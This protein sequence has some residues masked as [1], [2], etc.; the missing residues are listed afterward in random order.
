MRSLTGIL[1]FLLGTAPAWAGAQREE[2]L[3]A[4]VRLA[5]HTAVDDT[6]AMNIAFANPAQAHA[7][8][9]EMSRRLRHKMPNRYMRRLF[10]KT[11]QYESI[12]AGLDPQ[13]V[14]GLIQVESGFNKYAVSSAGAMGYMQVM[15]FWIKQVG[16]PDDDL[17]AMRTNL[18]YGCTILRYYLDLEKGNLFR[19]LGLYNGSLGQAWYPERVL[20]AWRHDWPYHA[21][22]IVHDD[23]AVAQLGTP[24]RRTLNA[25]WPR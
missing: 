24:E 21:P 19:A 1:I 18:V 23:L 3:S 4:N 6:A 8:L 5:L 22:G 16:K 20:A 12:R 15:P 13:L 14:L 17:F 10:L 2:P 7:W 11:V 9:A 25:P